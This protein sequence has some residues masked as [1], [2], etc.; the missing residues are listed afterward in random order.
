MPISLAERLQTLTARPE[1]IMLL[2]LAFLFMVK[3]PAALNSDVQPWDEGMYAAR[4]NSIHVNGDFLDQSSHSVG[5]FYSGSHPP[6]LIW[7]GYLASLVFGFSPVTLKLLMLLISLCAVAVLFL[8]GKHF[9]DSQTGMFAAMAFSGN[10]LFNVFSKRFQLDMPYVLLMLISFYFVLRLSAQKQLINAV[11]AGIFFGFCLMSKILVGLFIPLVIIS[12]VLVAQRKFGLSLKEFLVIVVTGLAIA[13]PWHIYM[14]VQHG[15]EFTDYF[16]S[17]HLFDR[18]FKGVEMNQKSSGPLYHFN[19]LLSII[20]FGIVLLFAFINNSKKFRQLSFPVIFLWIWTIAG[21]VI[22]TVFKTKLE[23]YLLL[24]LPSVSL[25]IAFYM[26]EINKE[27]LMKKIFIVILISLNTLWFATEEIR[28]L[29]RNLAGENVLISSAVLMLLLSITF[30]LSRKIVN[31][32]NLK[33]A[34]RILIILTFVS[35]N[36]YYLVNKPLWEDRFRISKIVKMIGDSRLK[37]I[38]Y[39]GSDYRYNPQFTYYFDGIDL[40]WRSPAYEYEFIDTN[41]GVEKVKASLSVKDSLTFVLVEKD[42]LNRAEYPESDS[43]VPSAF[44]LLHKDTGYELYR[45]VK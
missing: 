34:L 23:S 8:I 17:F 41:T 31:D 33:F 21:F 15:K 25:L 6:L 39:V 38:V 2:M 22:L 16:F 40:G 11:L 13:L 44:S 32:L 4:V 1:G 24:V 9:F 43:F 10:I 36:I 42:K 37:K 14:I 27:S 20:P 12:C 45:R 28:P 19:Y 3:L 7:T 30:L 5:K 26:N 18:A 29:L 35:T